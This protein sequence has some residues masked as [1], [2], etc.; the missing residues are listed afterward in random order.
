VL[1]KTI[2]T[3]HEVVIPTIA[4]SDNP[5]NEKTNDFIQ[6]KYNT[7]SRVGYTH[8]GLVTEI[9]EEEAK[10]KKKKNLLNTKEWKLI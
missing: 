1:T 5:V 8:I 4:D 10:V 2:T 6:K 7:W 9:K 3:K